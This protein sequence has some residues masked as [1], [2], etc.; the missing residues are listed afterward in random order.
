MDEHDESAGK[1]EG[2]GRPLDGRRARARDGEQR[3]VGATVIGYF[4]KGAVRS[5]AAHEP[6]AEKGDTFTGWTNFTSAMAV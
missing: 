2:R 4:E 3:R 5:I 6:D 1:E